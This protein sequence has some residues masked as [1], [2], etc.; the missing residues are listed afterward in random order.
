MPR[1]KEESADEESTAVT[2]MH[3]P[4][5]PGPD[6][7]GKTT[8][9]PRMIEVIVRIV[10]AGVVADPLV[11]VGMHVRCGGVPGRLA[12]AGRKTRARARGRRTMRRYVSATHA[13]HSPAPTVSSPAG[14]VLRKCADG[15]HQCRPDQT[16]QHFHECFVTEVDTSR[17]VLHATSCARR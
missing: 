15:Q 4:N 5:M 17:I 1:P 16:D 2:A 8:V 9:L 11:A 13:V 3:S 10:A 12:R 14:D 7:A 6:G